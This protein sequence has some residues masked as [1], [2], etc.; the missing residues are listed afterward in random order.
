MEQTKPYTILGFSAAGVVLSTY[1]CMTTPALGEQY[2]R[3]ALDKDGV[4]RAGAFEGYFPT[5][6]D[7]PPELEP[8]FRAGD[9]PTG[10]GK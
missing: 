3:N 2:T 10:Q 6:K 9:W 4:V 5:A 1:M 7:V 8:A